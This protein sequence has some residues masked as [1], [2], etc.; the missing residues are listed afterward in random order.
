VARW[1]TV[2][3]RG[4]RARRAAVA[5]FVLDSRG[6]A[7]T[8]SVLVVDE[9]RAMREILVEQLAAQRIGAVAVE[10]AVEALRELRD[11]DFDAILADVGIRGEDGLELLRKA[12]AIQPDVPVILMTAFAQVPIRERA[13]REG[14]FACIARPYRQRELIELLE[15]SF[16][17]S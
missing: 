14:A 12:H 7:A 3:E 4:G 11:H 13:A 9:D 10:S 8:R 2:R 6:V 17:R 1:R 5:R 16:Q 15:H